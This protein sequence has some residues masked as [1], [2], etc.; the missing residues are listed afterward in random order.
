[1]AFSAEIAEVPVRLLLDSGAQG[2]WISRAAVAACELALH[3][4]QNVAVEVANGNLLQTQEFCTPRVVLQELRTFPH[5]LVLDQLP[6]GFDVILGDGWLKQFSVSLHFGQEGQNFALVKGMQKLLPIG[7]EPRSVALAEVQPPKK[8]P[9]VLVL[10]AKAFQKAMKTAKCCFAVFVTPAG[11]VAEQVPPELEGVLEEFQGVFAPLPPGLPPE[12]PVG[13][14]IPLVEG[15]QTP[16]KRMYRLSPREKEEVEKQIA[17]QI[18]QGWIEPSTSSFGAPI[19][20]VEKKDGGLRMCVDYRALN[21]LTV[22]NRYPLPRIDDLFD[23]LRDARVFSTLDLQAGY[24][25]IRI[26]PQDVPK[27][28]FL[29]HKGLYQYR[30]LS[31][32]LCNAPS[33]F[34]SVMNHTLAPLL[35][36]CVVVYID[37]I[38]VFSRTMEEH[39]EHLAQV[40]KL[41]REEHFYCKR[42]KC[43]FGKAEV[44]FLG[45]VIGHGGVQVDP[46]KVEVL[47]RWP[48]PRTVE[49][50]RSFL[51]LATYFR[52]F[53]KDFAGIANPL[54][55]LT[56]KGLAWAWTPSCQ[57][58]FETLKEKLSSA[59]VLAMP[60]FSA[61][62][63]PFEVV[64]DAS[65]LSVGALLTQGGHV[66][67][68]ESRKLTPAEQ[69]YTT[70][71]Q[72]LLAVVHAMRTWRCYLEGVKCVVVTDHNPLT[73]FSTQPTLSRRQARWSE[74]LQNFDFE[75]RYRPGAF[76]PA[77]ALSRV[78]LAA[79]MALT[80]ASAR[81]PVAGEARQKL[82]RKEPAGLLDRC[83]AGYKEDPWFASHAAELRAQLG[84]DGLYRDQ[85]GVVLVP[86]ADSLRQD[87]LRELHDSPY[88][89]HLGAARTYEQLQRVFSWPSAREDVE[90]YVRTCHVCQRDKAVHTGPRG[91]LQPLEIPG[92]KWE[93]VGM[94]FITQLPLT[95]QGNTQILVFVD[96]CTKMVHLA[97]LPEGASAGDVALCFRR[98]VFRLHG[99]PR[100]IVSDRDR[101][102]TGRFWSE[103]LRLLGTSRRMSTAYHP[104][105][106]GQ[107]ERM[108]SVVEE[109]LRHWV[110]SSLDNWDTLLDCAEF[111]INNAKSQSTQTTPF[112]LNYGYDPLTPLSLEARTQLPAV[113]EC[114]TTMH[115]A[116]VEAKRALQAAQERQ[117]A[118][119]DAGRK[120][121]EFSEGQEVL[122][123][124]V[125]LR[126]KQGG[127]RKL[128]PKWVGPFRVKRRVGQLAY[129]LELPPSLPVH[130]VFHTAL[131]RPFRSDGR[132]QPPPLPLQVAGEEEYEVDSILAHRGSG[133]G[134]TFLV[135][136][137][138]YG[139]E[140]DTWEP[141]RNLANAKQLLAEYY[142][143][144]STP[145]S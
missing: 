53:I 1:M 122:L 144:I 21:K 12:R 92:R 64:C 95:P 89:G 2:N 30:V 76:N 140:H 127:A 51:G 112:R 110:N 108:N 25:Q 11:G 33:T 45:H 47:Q 141:L 145:A 20:F 61:T 16:V 113:Q 56:K 124:S 65:L 128:M 57:Q 7:N 104:Q 99:L 143:K 29:T 27:T 66:V 8:K 126:F 71:E 84:T 117:R 134:R 102:F 81:R 77:D 94:D 44:A 72:E 70:T 111:A 31:F 10:G 138:G 88:G 118:Y 69:R 100:T 86:A 80:R 136:W 101:K 82:P 9:E 85:R 98:E 139:P 15:A 123:N 54:H 129:E 133:R 109:M 60:D 5:C 26:S 46:K 6:G 137:K 62:A 38:L 83:R 68:Y 142:A 36:K 103:L 120:E 23:Q 78:D 34:Q 39:K 132:H 28:A 41:L 116:L 135:R 125:N 58:A 50:L 52:K 119:Y 13:H 55:Q 32:G 63:A 67:A 4:C 19:L 3:P 73:F 107:T 131:L 96:R 79:L 35:G 74:F 114:I 59:P 106:D 87:I 90:G 115:T 91:L 14:V 24:H 42:S 17:Y 18:Q 40:L 121:Q 48:V 75:W 43:S 49:Q 97:A 37:D 130:P 93:S 105:T 22:K